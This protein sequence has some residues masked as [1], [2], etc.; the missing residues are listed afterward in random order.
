MIKMLVMDLDDTLLH[1]DK[2]ISEFTEVTL[3]KAHASG[4][5][6]VFATGRPIR[7][8]RSFLK[9]ID[10]DAVICHNGAVTL[11]DNE[12]IG[13]HYTVPYKDA[14][15]ILNYMKQ[16]YPDKKLSVEINDKIYANF[17]VMLFWGKGASD[18]AIL[19]NTFIWT[20]FTNLPRY[21]ADKVIIELN[22]EEEY[23][24]IMA[25]LPTNLYALRSDGGKLCMV[26]NKAA[27]K[28]NAVKNLAEEWNIPIT[29]IAAF[30]DDYNDVELLEQCGIGIAMK[31]AI[32]D[33][34]NIADVITDTNNNDGVAKYIS[35]F[36][37]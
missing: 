8:V 9:Q 10:C 33:V 29:D 19:K 24:T 11:I 4:V 18:K 21:D 16:K 20:D 2:T 32:P 25:L 12:V 7:T 34:I 15:R 17:D 13:Q 31:N 30:G 5:K 3:K 27:K 1:T 36:I 23:K 37:L 14:I 6:I 28:L 35:D 22:A 26:M